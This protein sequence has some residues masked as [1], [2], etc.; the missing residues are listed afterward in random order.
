MME[1]LTVPALYQPCFTPKCVYSSA[2]YFPFPFLLSSSH[3][4]L[5]KASVNKQSVHKTPSPSPLRRPGFGF[6]GSLQEEC[7]IE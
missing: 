6:I 5:Q 3:I 2:P 4:F 1:K 7:P